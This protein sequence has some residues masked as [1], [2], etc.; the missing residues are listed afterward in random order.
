MTLL[1]LVQEFQEEF[2]KENQNKER[3]DLGASIKIM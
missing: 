3:K 2:K 1:L